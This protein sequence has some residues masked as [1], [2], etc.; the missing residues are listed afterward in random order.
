MRT[1]ARRIEHAF[2]VTVQRSHEADLGEH[3][4]PVVLGDQQQRLHRGL[5]FVGVML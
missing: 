4:W 5:P 3:R 1:F 2:D